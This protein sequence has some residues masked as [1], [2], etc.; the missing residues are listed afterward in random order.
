MPRKKKNKTTWFGFGSPPNRK[1]TKRPRKPTRAETIASLKKTAAVVA[2]VCAMAGVAVGFGYME[3]Y[4][5]AVSPVTQPAGALELISPPQWLNRALQDKI[6]MAAGGYTFPLGDDT[7]ADIA[8]GLQNLPWL[9]NVRTRTTEKTIHIHAD[10][11]KPSAMIRSGNKSYYLALVRPDDLIYSADWPKVVLLDYIELGELPI[12][13]IKGFSPKDMPPVGGAWDAPEVTTAVELITVLARMDEI[14]SREKPLL[15]EL[16]AIDVFN[17]DGRKNKNDAHVILYAKDGT[18]IRWGAAY[19][20]SRLY[21]EATEQE[22][23][24][25]LY[26]FYKEHNNTIQCIQN[27]ICQYVELRYSQKIFPRPE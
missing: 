3:R 26:T 24:A 13:E 16:A 10:Y 27:Q 2:A 17:F 12:V 1:K 20:K 6:A 18:E 7:A 8:A 11:R 15:Q 21:L 5:H 9:Y 25:T 19:G 14:S 23:L 22:K 4:V